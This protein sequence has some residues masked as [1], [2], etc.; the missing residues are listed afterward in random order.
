MLV[1]LNIF[2]FVPDKGCRKY[3]TNP[4]HIKIKPKESPMGMEFHALSVTNAAAE[5]A[6]EGFK[7]DCKKPSKENKVEERK[8]I[9]IK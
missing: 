7:R 6:E 1:N 3:A 8:T 9:I 2:N 5:K 4:I